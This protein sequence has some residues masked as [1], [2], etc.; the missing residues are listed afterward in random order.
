MLAG[1]MAGIAEHTIMFP[2]DSVKTRM[3][4]LYPDPKAVYN[5]TMHAF[6]TITTTE[7]IGRLWRG[8]MSV[9]VGAGPAHAVYF[10]T[11]EQC[12]VLFG[13]S[14]I[15]HSA[16]GACATIAA[17]ALMN[18]F[19]VV[20]QRMQLY[21][22][23]HKSVFQ[24]ISR[25]YST[26]GLSAFYVSYPTTLLLNIPFHAI[27]FPTYEYFKKIMP[28]SLVGHLISGSFAGGLAAA[29][30]TPIDVI[31]TL[32]QTKGQSLHSDIKEI[33]GMRNA[34]QFVYKADGLSGFFRGWRPRVA[35]H[36]PS[37]AVCW[38]TYEY[39]KWMVNKRLL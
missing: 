12:K 15:S 39:F 34:I 25:V 18:P 32:L 11:Y 28:D 37:I 5:G 21:G 9:V 23:E 20:K 2:F 8:V 24:C 27:Q 10:G 16:A 17:D 35:I 26:E 36:T 3:Q 1:A 13:S 29:L 4:V 7:G 19:D 33:N 38:A 30:T 31:K 22:S 6:Q 14:S